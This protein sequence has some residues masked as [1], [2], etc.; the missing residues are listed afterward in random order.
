MSGAQYLGYSVGQGCKHQ[1][2]AKIVSFPGMYLT[3]M[4]GYIVQSQE[5]L[6]LCTSICFIEHKSAFVSWIVFT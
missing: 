2:I 6:L 5:I 3:N 4:I 1:K